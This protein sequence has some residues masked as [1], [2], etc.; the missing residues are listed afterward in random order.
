M[1]KMVYTNKIDDEII[2][3]ENN[4]LALYLEKTKK[5][6]PL[7][8]KSGYSLK[9]GLMWKYFPRETV[10]LQRGSFQNGYQC[11]VY[12]AVQKD[13]NEVRIDSIDGEADYYPLSITWMISSIFRNFFKLN[14]KLYSYT[15]DADADLN[16]FLSQLKYPR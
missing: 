4:M 6:M 10:I 3:H 14:A 15:D 5:Y 12:C 1:K 11:Y 16:K 7:F 8:E 13:G 2:F 9:V